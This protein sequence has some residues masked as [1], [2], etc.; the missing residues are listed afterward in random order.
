M[1][2]LITRPTIMWA[3]P[4]SRL[5]MS[6][7]IIDSLFE[8]GRPL[9]HWFAL[10]WVAWAAITTAASAVGHY[11]RVRELQIIVGVDAVMGAV[12]VLVMSESGAPATAVLVCSAVMVVACGLGRLSLVAL[13]ALP[14]MAWS[15]HELLDLVF[16]HPTH[17]LEI[18]GSGINLLVLAIQL[19]ALAALAALVHRN[20]RVDMFARE[21]KSIDML[22]PDR[23]FEFDLQEMVNDLAR[24]FAPERA[25]CLISRPSK[26][27][28][29][30]QF[31]HNCDLSHVASDVPK[32][33]ELAKQLPERAA[34]Y[35][36]EENLCWP[37]DED[38]P[39]A[40]SE[41]EQQCALYLKRE[42]FVVAMVQPLQIGQLH[43]LLVCAAMKPIDACLFTDAIKIEK[44]IVVL[45]DF[46]ARMSEAERQFIGDAH[47]VARRDLHDGVLQSMAAL[48]MKLLTIA[49]RQDLNEH[50]AHLELRKA[51][52]IL[53]LEQVRLRGL[54]ET[55][56]SET[57]TIN[58]VARLDICLRAISLQWEV[59]AKLEAEEPAIPVDRESAL[60]IEHLVREAV[61]NAVRH[62]KISAL[63]V[64][65]SLKHDVLLIAINDS[66]KEAARSGEGGKSMPL[67][68]ASLQHRLRLVKGTAY[69]EGL[70][71]GTLLSISIPMQQVEDA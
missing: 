35:D 53:T 34:I 20:A 31:S 37:L 65:L 4:V 45:T 71:T 30:R 28:G 69:S 63:T 38:R 47:D 54:L 46:L 51:A 41:I 3:A 67:Q 48:R 11:F 12:S 16:V 56:A 24:I 55:S 33:V 43:G 32:I 7:T 62:A 39:R 18:K 15:A 52:D 64:M 22:R 25:F 14:A 27:L 6:A 23:S 21:C 61:A 58:L 57:D 9:T 26:N 19:V 36:T 1:F 60:N 17:L 70:A 40:F 42:H 68:S 44:N 66:A 8:Q 2:R 49:K 59:D 29:Y 50:P 10:I 13:F 5:L